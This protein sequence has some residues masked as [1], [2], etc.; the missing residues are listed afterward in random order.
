MCVFVF[1]GIDVTQINNLQLRVD[2]I[3]S[4]SNADLKN[5]TFDVVEQQCYFKV[6][7][8]EAEK[9]PLFHS[10]QYQSNQLSFTRRHPL[11]PPLRLTLSKL[12][13]RILRWASALRRNSSPPLIMNKRHR[14]QMVCEQQSCKMKSSGNIAHPFH[15]SHVWQPRDSCHTAVF[16][17]SSHLVCLSNAN[18]CLSAR[19]GLAA[20]CCALTDKPI[21][22]INA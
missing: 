8:K 13:D 14:G 18:G 5:V 20:T 2:S 19:A 3:H 21:W 10:R 9:G 1:F 7:C 15:S 16:S 17:E 22:K 4:I 6:R 12:L 11:Q